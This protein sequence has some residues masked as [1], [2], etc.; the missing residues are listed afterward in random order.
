M[1]LTFFTKNDLNSLPNFFFDVNLAE[2]PPGPPTFLYRSE[3]VQ[4]KNP[5]F[6]FIYTVST[7]PPLLTRSDPVSTLFGLMTSFFSAS[8]G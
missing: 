4:E 6:I 5:N 3:K 7:Q 1:G 2:S 8:R